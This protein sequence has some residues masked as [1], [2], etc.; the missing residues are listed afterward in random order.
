MGKKDENEV[1]EVADNSLAMTEAQK[2]EIVDYFGA[3]LPGMEGISFKFANIKVAHQSG[4]F[5]MPDGSMTKN[6]KG[7]I[8]HVQN[9]GAWWEVGFNESGG[10]S[11]PSCFSLD[12]I[13]PSPRSSLIQSNE[14]RSCKNNIFGSD[15][16]RGKSCKN[17]KRTYILINGYDLPVR[18]TV[19]PTSLKA[20]D[21]YG[22]LLAYKGI[23]Y[24]MALTQFG[25]KEERNKDGIRF[26]GLVLT[27]DGASAK[28]KE[29]A[30]H[31]MALRNEYMD[32]MKGEEITG[33]EYAPADAE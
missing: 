6:F 1:K 16:K 22:S 20:I 28:S 33:E 11:P 2:H 25:L 5:E 24:I 3:D 26:S 9:A 7:I 31:L 12:G 14:C 8:L 27:A 10:G 17:M 19:P 18:L 29:E 30:D 15:G 13:R 23:R 21:T 4:A 32:A